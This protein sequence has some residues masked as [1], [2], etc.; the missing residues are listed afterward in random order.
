[1]ALSCGAQ[2]A[3][4]MTS[5][6]DSVP[7]EEAVEYL[8]NG[9]AHA[10]TYTVD[11]DGFTFQYAN[12]VG[13]DTSKFENRLVRR[14]VADPAAA[15]S[16]YL[17]ELVEFAVPPRS[18]YILQGPWRYHYSHAILGRGQVPKLVSALSEEPSRRT[19]IIF[20]DVKS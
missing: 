5:T 10:T 4:S 19:S 2:A 17:P 12:S 11:A 14:V 15:E 7:T 3:K 6:A 18:L 1:M 20:R 13:T 8:H 9:A 16:S